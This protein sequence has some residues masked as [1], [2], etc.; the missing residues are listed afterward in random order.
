MIVGFQAKT[1]PLAGEVIVTV[2]GVFA[3]AVVT[4]IVAAALVVVAPES[5]V[6]FAVSV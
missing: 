4:V 1:V 5:S 2:G 3:G 6:A